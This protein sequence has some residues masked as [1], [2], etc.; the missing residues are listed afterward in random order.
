MSSV[1]R[2]ASLISSAL[3]KLPRP[4]AGGGGSAR[5]F[6]GG[7]TGGKSSADAKPMSVFDF[8]FALGGGGR[9]GLGAAATGGAGRA[10]LDKVPLATGAATGGRGGFAPIAG[11]G[12]SL[13]GNEELE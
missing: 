8:C 3:E 7:F 5:G 1:S 12:G 10:A 2:S 6:S 13:P 11:G 9:G 4:T